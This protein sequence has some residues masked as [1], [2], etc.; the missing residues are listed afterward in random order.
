[1]ATFDN[2]YPD[3]S[4]GTEVRFEGSLL[5]KDDK[6]HTCWHCGRKTFWVDIL[7]PAPLCSEECCKAKWDEYW[8]ANSKTPNDDSF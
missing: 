2:L 4:C 3:A 6:E 1:M 7:F 5:V 8:E